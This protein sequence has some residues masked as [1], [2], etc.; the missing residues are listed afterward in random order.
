VIFGC[1]EYLA[2]GVFVLRESAR[3]DLRLSTSSNPVDHG[4]VATNCLKDRNGSETMLSG[5]KTF[6]SCHHQIIVAD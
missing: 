2:R 6:A 4:S 3:V 1:L 5:P